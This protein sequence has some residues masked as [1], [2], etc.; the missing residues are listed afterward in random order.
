MSANRPNLVFVYPDQFRQQAMGFMEQ[1]PVVTPNL[2][3]FASESLVF[4]N[5]VSNRPL[6]SPH[7]AMVMT[8]KYPHAN[9]VLTNCNS[10]MMEYGNYLKESERCLSDVLSD[11]GY[12]QGYIG[13]YHLDAP[14]EVDYPYTE[15]PRRDG[16][17][18]DAYTPPGPRRHGFDF[19]HAYGCH[20]WHLNPHY[21]AGDARVNERVDVDG[22]SVKH[23]TD[24]ALEY[25][26]NQDGKHRSPGSPFSVFVAY[27]P[28]HPPFSQVPLQYVAMYGDKSDEDL[29]NR[30]NVNLADEAIRRRCQAKNYF[31]AVTGVDEQFGR[32]LECLRDE[33]L[34]ENTIVVFAS[35]HG[36]MLGSHGRMQ[37]TVWYDETLLVPFIARWPGRVDPGA[38]DLLLSVPDIMPSLLHLM[39]L[40]DQVPEGV[41]G[42]DYSPIML[43]QE[44]A[45][46]SSALYLDFQPEYPNEG[47][48]WP[49]GGRRGLRTHQHT[50][51]AQRGALPDDTYI[52][53]DNVSDPY[54][55][56]NV[57][58]EYPAIVKELMEELDDWLERIGDPWLGAPA[59]AR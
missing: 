5:A 55:L 47:E 37:K 15:G 14:L 51:V 52:L 19:W 16:V 53:Y 57:A 6:C 59:E 9:G 31:A 27:N 22:W 3:R 1:D 38:D 50:F 7:R 39:G 54:Q 10:R 21:W 33:G 43:G 46:P 8:G 4:T 29:L 28:P 49:S 48:Q 25:I 26:R 17:A 40:G 30:P 11:A 20:D 34:E 2:D 41:E 36:E 23:E 13:K 18:W 35:D 32:I 58:D 42:S 12:C 44:C 56:R 45:R 24:V